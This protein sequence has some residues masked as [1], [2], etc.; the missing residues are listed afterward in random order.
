[1]SKTLS[2]KDRLR[3]CIE[4][5]NLENEKRLER[6]LAIGEEENRLNNLHKEF[7][8]SELKKLSIKD[9]NF[10]NHYKSNAEKKIAI[11]S[12]HHARKS[13]TSPNKRKTHPRNEV[14]EAISIVKV[15]NPQMTVKLIINEVAIN[16]NMT[17]RA[18]KKHYYDN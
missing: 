1:M 13:L 9:Q 16:L 3:K 2:D 7:V 15:K 8:Q 4:E 5:R 6:T 12:I 11:E 18:V 17:P 10:V 14:L